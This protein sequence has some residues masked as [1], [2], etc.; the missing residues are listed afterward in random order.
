MFKNFINTLTA[1]LFSANAAGQ[2]FRLLD[3]DRFSM[4]FYEIGDLRDPYYPYPS[5]RSD[6]RE[7]WRGG[8]ATNFDLRLLTYR[9]VG[10][11]WD[12]RLAGNGTNK[13]F[14]T[15]E[16]EYKMRLQL[17]DKFN[18]HHFHRSRHL[19]DEASQHPFPLE[20]RFTA[21]Y[22]FFQK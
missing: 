14:R 3:M 1:L 22:V 18:L 9:D 15:V 7:K 11:Y 17:G 2:D 4:E 13:Q 5:P 16:W 20:N 21:E 19:L 8:I 12:N 6:A 10:L